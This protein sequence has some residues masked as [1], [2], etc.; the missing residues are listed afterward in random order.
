VPPDVTTGRVVV[1]V[2]GLVVVDDGGPVVG[3]PAGGAST[4]GAV[5][6]TGVGTVV[7][8]VVATG[9]PAAA[10]DPGCSRAKVTPMKEAAA[11]ETSARACVIRRSCTS[12]RT[13]SWGEY[14]FRV[15]LMASQVL[16]PTVRNEPEGQM[17]TMSLAVVPSLGAARL[18]A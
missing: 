16:C 6:V 2:G 1:V 13:R 12:A 17:T 9:A 4:S 8:V 18:V 11:A 15:R 14:L 7:V 5:G 3:V 10:P